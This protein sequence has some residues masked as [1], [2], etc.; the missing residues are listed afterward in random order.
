MR[1][2]L[3]N[4]TWLEIPAVV[5]VLS[6]IGIAV[7]RAFASSRADG[8]DVFLRRDMMDDRERNLY[9]K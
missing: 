9:R 8:I 7:I 5:I 1:S 6:V 4:M 2:F 3:V